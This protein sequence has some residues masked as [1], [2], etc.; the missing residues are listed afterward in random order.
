M[1]MRI[2]FGVAPTSQTRFRLEGFDI[3]GTDLHGFALIFRQCD[4]D[5]AEELPI[6]WVIGWVPPRG[7]REAQ[8][9]VDTF[10]D[11]IT[12]WVRDHE[13]PPVPHE[14]KRGIDAPA[15][16]HLRIDRAPRLDSLLEEPD[17]DGKPMWSVGL[18]SL[19][20][21]WPAFQ[22]A[23]YDE[24]LGP[25]AHFFRRACVH[26]T[27]GLDVIALY[28]HD[29]VRGVYRGDYT[30]AWVPADREADANR[31]VMFLNSEIDR[32]R[33]EYARKRATSS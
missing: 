25:N 4:R 21:T 29:I 6:E 13:R 2:G 20:K 18:I 33:A 10:N 12:S 32:V 17:E 16:F 9:W 5:F 22:A 26:P 23:G 11:A 19:H 15:E 30:C 31:W 27:T 7:Q 24:F 14:G 3:D 28:L 8:G 1:R